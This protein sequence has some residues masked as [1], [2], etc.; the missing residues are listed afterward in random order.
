VGLIPGREEFNPALDRSADRRARGLTCRRARR[1][2]ATRAPLGPT[3]GLSKGRAL[4]IVRA[5]SA[6]T[7]A[8]FGAASALALA[9]ASAAG[10]ASGRAAPPAGHLRSAYELSLPTAV[11]GEPFDLAPLSGKVAAVYFFSTWCLPC[12]QELK[13]LSTLQT[14]Y[15]SKGFA[16][17]AIGMDLEGAKVLAPFEKATGLPFPVLVA[18]ARLRSGARPYGVIHAV[19]PTVLLDREGKIAAAYEGPAEPLRLESAVENLL[20]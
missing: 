4:G 9:V 16:V 15:E 1:A 3:R 5:V 6:R 7:A 10:C 2:Q 20:R 17:V 13:T 14:K 8:C 11:G 19:P 18:D 12:L